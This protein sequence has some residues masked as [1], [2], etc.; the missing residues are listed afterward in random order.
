M[1]PAKNEEKKLSPFL[2]ALL[3]ARNTR[4]NA[5]AAKCRIL[6]SSAIMAILPFVPTRV[7]M[8]DKFL[9]IA[10]CMT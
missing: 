5:I 3:I 4:S 7:A 9:K 6:E 1:R 8:L 10:S 2:C